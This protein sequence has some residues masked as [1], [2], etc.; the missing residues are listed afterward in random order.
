MAKQRKKRGFFLLDLPIYL[1]WRRGSA[2]PGR[3]P[4]PL[5]DNLPILSVNAD[6]PPRR[7]DLAYSSTAV[8]Y[9]LFTAS[10]L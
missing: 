2:E 8:R 9:V 4:K 10:N 5:H 6:I 1:A 3:P 7:R